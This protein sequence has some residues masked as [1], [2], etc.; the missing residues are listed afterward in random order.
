[1][2]I[3]K[4][5]DRWDSGRDKWVCWIDHVATSNERR[6]GEPDGAL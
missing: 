3:V 4:V 2:L 5:G 1:M 6:N